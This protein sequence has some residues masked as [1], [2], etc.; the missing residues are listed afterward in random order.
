MKKFLILL[1]FF[2]LTACQFSNLPAKPAP[3]DE[4]ISSF[5]D[6]INAGYP[7]MESYP[8][9]CRTKSGKHF[10]EDITVPVPPSEEVP[11]ICTMDYTPVCALV[12]VQCVTAP[13]PPLFETKGNACTAKSLGSMLLGY[14]PGECEKD[15]KTECSADA[16]CK[17]PGDYA[18]MSRCPFEAKCVAGSCVVVC[19]QPSGN[20]PL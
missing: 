7:A 13:C 10:T 5:E 15:L 17:L 4:M 3:D 6:C 12:Q 8:R 1:P 18:A 19:P 11:Q 9:Q 20:P 16:D 2:L 14:T